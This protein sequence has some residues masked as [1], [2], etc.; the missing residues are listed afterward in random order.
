LGSLV[1]SKVLCV[2]FTSLQGITLRVARPLNWLKA[3]HYTAV[4]ITMLLRRDVE[5]GVGFVS[6]KGVVGRLCRS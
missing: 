5:S 2:V 1:R 6:R 4:Q 3:R